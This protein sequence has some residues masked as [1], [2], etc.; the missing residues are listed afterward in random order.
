MIAICD[1]GQARVAGLIM[2]AQWETQLVGLYCKLGGKD[3]VKALA[4]DRAQW[5]KGI[6]KTWNLGGTWHEKT[7]LVAKWY[8]EVQPRKLNF[9]E[10]A[11]EVERLLKGGL[12]EAAAALEVEIA[13]E[14]G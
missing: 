13:S 2:R 4:A 3:A 5:A 1:A 8:G 9:T 6:E 14:P 11:G 12:D 7:E 10:L